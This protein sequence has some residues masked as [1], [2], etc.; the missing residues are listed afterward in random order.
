[1]ESK[2]DMN[3]LW[4]VRTD[5][6]MM[7]NSL[8][9]VRKWIPLPRKNINKWNGKINKPRRTTRFNKVR[10][11]LMSTSWESSH[12]HYE[13]VTQV[14]EYTS[15]VYAQPKPLYLTRYLVHPLDLNLEGHGHSTPR[16]IHEESKT[17]R[18]ALPQ[19]EWNTQFLSLCSH[20]L[21][22]ISF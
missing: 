5:N 20:S 2:I 7:R 10:P 12:L 8:V 6:T 14:Q 3:G 16:A 13:R 4:P 19:L 17:L 21:L 9:R 15:Q 1:M 22:L 11:K 18:V